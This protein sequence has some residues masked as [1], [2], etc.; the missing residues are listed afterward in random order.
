MLDPV[1][2]NPLVGLVGQA[3]HGT[4]RIRNLEELLVGVHL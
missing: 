2:N 4:V 3:D 1:D